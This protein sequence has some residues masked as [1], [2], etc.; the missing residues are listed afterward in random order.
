MNK[1]VIIEFLNGSERAF[2]LVYDQYAGKV[3]RLGRQIL[4]SEEL[5]RDF[6]QDFFVKLWTKRDKFKTAESFDDYFFMAARNAALNRK[7]AILREQLA[8]EEFIRESEPRAN[9]VDNYI[10]EKE[11]Q[12]L[13]AKA[14]ETST[15]RRQEIYRL[16]REKGMT[17]AEIA[18][19]LD[20]ARQ[21]VDNEMTSILKTIRVYIQSHLVSWGWMALAFVLL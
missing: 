17:A 18:Q 3:L 19:K 2:G 6:V 12:T 14:L 11:L 15:P 16:S 10:R 21:T 20:L 5:A 1:E 7:R 9:T 4:P 13:V 8:I